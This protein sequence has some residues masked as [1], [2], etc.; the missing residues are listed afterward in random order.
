MSR[1]ADASLTDVSLMDAGED[2]V[3]KLDHD[4]THKIRS[5]MF[6]FS[7]SVNVCQQ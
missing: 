4:D 2:V 5:N 3:A 6:D 7:A 1:N